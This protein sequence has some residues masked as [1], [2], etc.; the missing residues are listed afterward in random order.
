MYGMKHEKIF[1]Y[2]KEPFMFLEGGM[3][4]NDKEESIY[5]KMVSGNYECWSLEQLYD[6][7]HRL[8]S[9][10]YLKPKTLI[11][12]TTGVYVDNLNKL[13][14][15]ANTLDLSSIERIVL[16]LDTETEMYKT[17]KYF[18]EKYP[19]IKFYKFKHLIK[20][21]REDVVIKQI[22]L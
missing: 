20:G 7:P 8:G 21:D 10:P 17:L 1:D 6:M 4:L 15:L 13:I 2:D 12:G 22:Q 19:K 18:H 11:F 5:K 14:E 3:G 9:I 16:T